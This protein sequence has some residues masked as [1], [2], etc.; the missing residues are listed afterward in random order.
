MS[1]LVLGVPEVGIRWNLE[2][3][4]NYV[5]E[6]TS[7]T[8]LD[9]FPRLEP[10]EKRSASGNPCPERDIPLITGDS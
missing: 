6:L 1:A 2:F 3:L 7:D 8:P 5:R 9:G 10:F 4:L